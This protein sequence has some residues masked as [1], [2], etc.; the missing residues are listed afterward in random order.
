MQEHDEGWSIL[1]RTVDEI[2]L[3]CHTRWLMRTPLELKSVQRQ[4]RPSVYPTVPQ[5]QAPSRL[6]STVPENFIEALP[7]E[8]DSEPP[9]CSSTALPNAAPVSLVNCGRSSIAIPS[10]FG[11]FRCRAFGNNTR[12]FGLL[13][14]LRCQP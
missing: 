3:C 10:C 8:F 14:P 2:Y 13:L 1:Q 6:L 9:S 4:W 7:N 12:G 11:P 5:V